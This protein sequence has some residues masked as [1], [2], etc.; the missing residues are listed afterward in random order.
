MQ[1]LVLTGDSWSCG[2]WLC[3]G[4]D[5]IELNHPGMTEYLPYKT[6]NLSKGGGSNWE[7]LFSIFNYMNQRQFTGEEEYCVILFQTNPLRP[8]KADL[9]DVDVDSIIKQTESLEQLYTELLEIFYIKLSE[10]TKQYNAPV[11]IVGGLSDVDESIFSLY[12]NKENIICDSWLKLLY[13]PHKKSI[14]PLQ[15]SSKFFAHAKKLG[16]LDLCDQFLDQIDSNIAEL[17]E[18]LGLD[19]FGPTIGDFHP[20][21]DGHKIIAEQ[22][23][24]FIEK[25]TNA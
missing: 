5:S 13:P 15:I 3:H 7:S 6:I 18:V 8:K 2:E 21:R 17:N 4:P 10:F 25:Q 19:T 11:Y 23:I 1:Q 14:I 12:N 16:R 22:I 20:N 24:N 9:F